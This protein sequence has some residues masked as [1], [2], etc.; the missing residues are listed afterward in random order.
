[1]ANVRHDH[2]FNGTGCDR[3][4]GRAG[5]VLAWSG[6]FSI[7]AITQLQRETG[8]GVGVAK[9]SLRCVLFRVQTSFA[10][11]GLHALRFQGNVTNQGKKKSQTLM[12]RGLK[13]Q[14]ASLS[15]YLISR[16][17]ISLRS[18]QASTG[19]FTAI[20]GTS[21]SPTTT[22]SREQSR[23][24]PRRKPTSPLCSAGISSAAF[25]GW[26]SSNAA[27]L[28]G[29]ASCGSAV[30]IL[31][32]SSP[33]CGHGGPITPAIPV[34]RASTSAP[35]MK[36]AP[37]GISRCTPPKTSKRRRSKS[38]A[39]GATSPETPCSRLKSCTSRFRSTRTP[40]GTGSAFSGAT[41]APLQRVDVS[42]LAPFARSAA[43]SAIASRA[44]SAAI[45]SAG[46]RPV[47]LPAASSP[48]RPSSRIG[49][50]TK[51][52]LGSF[53]APLNGACI[54]G[55]MTRFSAGAQSLNV[56][57]S[58]PFRR[59]D[60][61]GVSGP[62]NSTPEPAASGNLVRASRSRRSQSGPAVKGAGA[63]D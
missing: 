4:S 26:N 30:A 3:G 62:C 40:S 43:P 48:L 19:P 39:G 12:R 33:G 44:A 41:R 8:T 18:C 49:T 53:P 14:S 13:G 42:R 5:A 17:K 22:N 57:R 16:K 54:R 11:L 21:R 2:A 59:V 46:L 31:S 50:Q 34:C 23:N 38:A 1:M 58:N 10:S 55:S 25:G 37:R 29:I 24:S 61:G 47:K 52:C 36:A 51:G 60:G 56:T 6:A 20:A 7:C 63:H 32:K 28:I 9:G 45:F 35:A 15:A 27:P